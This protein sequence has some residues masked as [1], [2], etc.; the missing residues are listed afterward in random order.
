M[1]LVSTLSRSSRHPRSNMVEFPVLAP[2]LQIG[3]Y[4]RLREAQTTFLLPA[5][6]EQVGRLDIETLDRELLEYAG[7]TRLA[8]LARRGLRGELLFATPY[9][10]S[11]KPTLL[12]Y[13]RLLLGFSQKEFYRPPFARFKRMETQGLLPNSL[14]EQ[15]APLCQSLAESAWLLLNGIPEIGQDVLRSLTML[16]YG[17]QLRGQRNVILGRE[18]I[19]TA[20]ALIKGIVA[21]ALEAEGESHLLV[22]SAAG[23]AYRIELAPDPDI[24]IRQVLAEGRLR[25]RIAIEVKGGTDVSNIHN[26]L[27]EA[28]K[29]HQKAKA[30]GFTEFWTVIN[31]PPL[32]E[33]AWKKETPTTTELFYLEDIVD[34]HNRAGERFREY[35]ISELG[36]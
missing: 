25:N 29:S 27:G 22:R 10:L 16:T 36:I 19:H 7:S 34:P 12:G 2:T 35:L 33:Q 14:R 31:V 5:L 26:R 32:A 20:F 21:H 6:L 9:V 30:E 23:R 17:A 28:E 24:A 15:L 1:L 8:H 3:F 11:S 13:Y 4:E 18:A